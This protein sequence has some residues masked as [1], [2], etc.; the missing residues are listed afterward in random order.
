[1]DKDSEMKRLREYIHLYLRREIEESVNEKYR[2]LFLSEES[3]IKPR[4]IKTNSSQAI[5]TG[6]SKKN[7]FLNVRNKK[8]NKSIREEIGRSYHSIRTEPYGL[9]DTIKDITTEIYPINGMYYA[10]VVRE[11]DNL[12]KSKMFKDEMEAEIWV[13]VTSME[14]TNS[15]TQ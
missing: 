13:R 5:K 15:F 3:V 11:K 10:E 8:R 9:S 4:K 7:I 14:M 12:K 2:I 6:K 1:M